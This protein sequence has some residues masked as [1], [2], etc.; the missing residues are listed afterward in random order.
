M[1]VG[2]SPVG[3]AAIAANGA[4]PMVFGFLADTLELSIVHRALAATPLDDS[5]ELGELLAPDLIHVLIDRLRATGTVLERAEYFARLTDTVRY[6]EALALGWYLALQEQV[7]LAGAAAGQRTVL[8]V[9]ADVLHATGAV[10]VTYDARAVL[11]SVIALN[12]LMTSG[13]KV[14]AVDSIEFQDA[15]ASQ[16]TLVTRL[17]DSAGFADTPAPALRLVALCA[18]AAVLGDTPLP[19]MEVFERLADEVLFYGV[20][21][22]GDAEYTGWAI[23]KGAVSEY[24]NYPFNGMLEFGGRYFG[25]GDTGLYEI[26]GTT[27]AGEPIEWAI[28]TALMDFGTGKLKRIPDAYI[29]FSGDGSAVWLRVF[30]EENGQRIESVYRGTPRPGAALHNDRIQIGRGLSAR[31]WQFELSGTG[32]VELDELAWRVLVLDRRLY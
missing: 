25:T 21:R 9:L 19:T 15:L 32:A 29:A 24:R 17:V 16:L 11:A 5:I 20:L 22:L 26:A 30:T 23:N 28:R 14:E 31:Y 4:E 1:A 10:N 27:D 12:T 18:D 6:R 13:W 3:H 2:E 8:A 7:G